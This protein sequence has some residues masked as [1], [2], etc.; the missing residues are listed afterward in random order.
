MRV[1]VGDFDRIAVALLQRPVRPV[2]RQRGEDRLD[3]VA[4]EQPVD[5]RAQL[6]QRPALGL[7]VAKALS[8]QSTAAI[9]SS[10]A[11]P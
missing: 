1:V 11:A 4:R 7:A 3:A 8:T 2:G 10:S 9:A 6:R 5:L